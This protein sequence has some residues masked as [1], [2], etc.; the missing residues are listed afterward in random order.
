MLIFIYNS[1][2]IMMITVITIKYFES[3]KSSKHSKSNEIKKKNLV[4]IFHFKYPLN[5]I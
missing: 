1:Y 5:R 2:D 3:E 4:N